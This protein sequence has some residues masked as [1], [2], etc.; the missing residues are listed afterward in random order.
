[1]M[2]LNSFRTSG[3]CILTGIGVPFHAALVSAFWTTPESRESGG[4][5]VH[6]QHILDSI[7]HI[8]SADN[9][10]QFRHCCEEAKTRCPPWLGI[11]AYDLEGTTIKPLCTTVPHAAGRVIVAV[12]GYLIDTDCHICGIF[13]SGK[14]TCWKNKV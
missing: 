3:D 14:P 6:A 2:A 10:G 8:S 13:G 1:M 7:E 9:E 12:A 5:V 4:A 11:L